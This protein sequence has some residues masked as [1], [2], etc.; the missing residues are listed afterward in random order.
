MTRSIA[1]RAN[2]AMSY[3]VAGQSCR[4]AATI[5]SVI[6]RDRISTAT[7]AGK[8]RSK[9]ESS[10]E[11]GDSDTAEPPGRLNNSSMRPLPVSAYP[12]DNRP[13]LLVRALQVGVLPVVAG[14]VDHLGL[15]PEAGIEADEIPLVDPSA[16]VLT[17]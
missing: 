7:R 9:T 2:V 13:L 4:Y 12:H 10:A 14:D 11:A 17:H 15:R 6:G 8:V 16:D 3:V 1:A 5:A